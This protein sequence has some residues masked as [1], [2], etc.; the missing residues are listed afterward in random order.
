MSRGP[1]RRLHPNEAQLRQLSQADSSVIL[2]R[3]GLGSGYKI[4][5][6]FAH[7]ARPAAHRS[8]MSLGTT[9]SGL[10]ITHVFSE[11]FESHTDQAALMLVHEII[12][13]RQ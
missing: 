2:Y 13:P 6:K 5:T 9:P 8:D 11:P 12:D 10:L 1:H 4:D 7:L 3:P